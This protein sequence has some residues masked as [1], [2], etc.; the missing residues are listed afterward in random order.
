[1]LKHNPNS[2]LYPRFRGW[3][4]LILHHAIP[5]GYNAAK[6]PMDWVMVQ[7]TFTLI[8]RPTHPI[9]NKRALNKVL[10]ITMKEANSFTKYKRQK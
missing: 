1:V 3:R 4:R 2:K 5:L 10:M 9:Q 6:A 7:I 8:T